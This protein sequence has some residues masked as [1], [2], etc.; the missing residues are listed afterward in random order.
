MAILLIT[1]KYL[2]LFFTTRLE[3]HSELT[4]LCCL[5]WDI[6][7]FGLNFDN[8]QVIRAQLSNKNSVVKLLSQSRETIAWETHVS[9]VFLYIISALR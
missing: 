3:I 8:V 2:S 6:T 1:H 7:D 5:L 9:S 4:G